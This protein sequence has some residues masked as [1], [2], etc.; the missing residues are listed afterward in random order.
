MNL[1]QAANLDYEKAMALLVL[2]GWDYQAAIFEI[3]EQER[4]DNMVYQLMGILPNIE[5]EQARNLLIQHNW[6]LE[7]AKVAY[8]N[9]SRFVVKL[10][11]IGLNSPPI[12][13][14]FNPDHEAYAMIEY[15][16]MVKPLENHDHYYKLYKDHQC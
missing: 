13:S 10:V 16:N 2:K 15:L 7:T 3:K 8:V 4:K 1:C 9:A 11:I 14:D 6:S 5:F 12:E